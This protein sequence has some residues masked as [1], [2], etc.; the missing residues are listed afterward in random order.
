MRRS[1][2]CSTGTVEFNSKPA[3]IDIMPEKDRYALWLNISRGG[4]I[5]ATFPITPEIDAITCL[6]MRG[7]DPI[8]FEACHFGC[9]CPKCVFDV[10]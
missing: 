5:G 2:A 10:K 7:A 9:N 3:A 1:L 6:K 4:V 8:D